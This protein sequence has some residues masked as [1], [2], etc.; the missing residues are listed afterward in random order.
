M[1]RASDDGRKYGT[2]S[3]VSGESSLAH[4]RSI[5]Y[6]QCCNFVVTHSVA[7]SLLVCWGEKK[8]NIEILLVEQSMNQVGHA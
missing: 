8:T 2:R 4:A 5:V 1:A 3:I 6:D 7:V